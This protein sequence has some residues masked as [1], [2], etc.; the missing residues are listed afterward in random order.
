[1]VRDRVT[2]CNSSC[3]KLGSAELGREVTVAQLATSKL[4]MIVKLLLC[5]RLANIRSETNRGTLTKGRLAREGSTI[6]VW[7]LKLGKG[8]T[9]VIVPLGQ[10]EGHAL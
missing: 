1:M 9:S 4:L 3:T 5:M 10:G 6:T 7:P 8:D 2:S